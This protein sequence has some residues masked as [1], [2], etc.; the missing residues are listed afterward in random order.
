MLRSSCRSFI[1]ARSMVII[2][3]A[4]ALG[5]CSWRASFPPTLPRRVYALCFGSVPLSGLRSSAH[6]CVFRVCV[7]CLRLVCASCGFLLL[8]PVLSVSLIDIA[9]GAD[10]NSSLRSALCLCAV[11]FYFVLRS[12]VCS[13]RAVPSLRSCSASN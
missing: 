9:P 10:P 6:S 8:Y 2:C 5:L 11:P 1:C 13:G 4:A 12:I 3:P 7:Y